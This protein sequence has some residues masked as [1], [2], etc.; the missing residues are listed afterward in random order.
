MTDSTNEARTAMNEEEFREAIEMDV[1]SDA[2][3]VTQEGDTTTVKLFYHEPESRI[4]PFKDSFG[5]EIMLALGS[6]NSEKLMSDVIDDIQLCS[7]PDDW[8]IEDK[9]GFYVV[10]LTYDNGRTW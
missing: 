8:R 4:A 2:I 9:S 1:P 7:S 3:S 6:P 10:T 5:N